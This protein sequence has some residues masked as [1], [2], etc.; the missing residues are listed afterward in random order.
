VV[1]DDVLATG[2]VGGEGGEIVRADVGDQGGRAV[3]EHAE[4]V[5]EAAQRERGHLD[6][7]GAPT[8]PGALRVVAEGPSGRDRVEH[9]QGRRRG[10]AGGR[11]GVE[12]VVEL[13]ADVDQ[14]HPGAA[15]GPARGVRRP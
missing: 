5:P 10:S 8:Q 13:A 14:D 7:V 2:N 15:D 4:P 3:R 1:A 6:V 9:Q 11:G 12:E